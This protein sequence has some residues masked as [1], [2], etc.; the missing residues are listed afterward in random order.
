M[1]H[2][3]QQAA[4]SFEALFL[5]NLLKAAREARDGGAL[6]EGD[7]ASGS[8]MDMAEEFLAQEIAKGGGCGLARMVMQQIEQRGAVS[9]STSESP[10]G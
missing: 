1:P 9:A 8:I 4:E 7:Q 5:G 6:A 10:P 3:I 2:N